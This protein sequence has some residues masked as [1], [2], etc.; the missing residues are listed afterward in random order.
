MKKP[1][2]R[3]LEAVAWIGLND[4]PT[5]TDRAIISEQITVAM[6]ADVYGWTPLAV[7]DMVIRFR[8]ILASKA[9]AR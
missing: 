9:V 6:V 7:A 5:E 4:E 8:E 3:M 2:Q 1:T